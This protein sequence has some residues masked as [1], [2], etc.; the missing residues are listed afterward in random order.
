MVTLFICFSTHATLLGMHARE[1][2][3]HERY[4]PPLLLLPCTVGINKD[5][6]HVC[7]KLVSFKVRVFPIWSMLIYPRCIPVEGQSIPQIPCTSYIRPRETVKILN[8]ILSKKLNI[9][10]DIPSKGIL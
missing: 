8:Q 3:L 1:T 4:R 5:I 2:K 10:F 9:I 6:R 7:R